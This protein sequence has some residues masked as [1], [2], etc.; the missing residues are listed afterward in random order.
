MALKNTAQIQKA[1]EGKK[2]ILITFKKHVDGD[3]MAS[4]IALKLFLEHMD[5]KADIVCDDF[6]LS[7]QYAFLK[8][9][10]KIKSKIGDL[11]QFI[12]TLDT[13]D[14]GLSELSYDMKENKLRIFITPKNG[15]ITKEQIKTSQTEFKYDLI[16]VLDTP[17][18]NALGNVYI[19]HEDFFFSTP[20][21]NIDHKSSN[22][23]FGAINIIDL[24]ASTTAEIIYTILLSLQ[25]NLINRHIA[26]AL[27]TGI[28]SGTNS[29]KKNKVRP[30]TLTIASKLVDLGADRSFIIKNLYQTKS[31]ATFKLWGSAL[32]NLQ[33]DEKYG[34]VWTILTRDDFI[35][36]GAKREDLNSIVDEL[37]TTSPDAKFILL[38]NEH[39]N[40]K[41]V[42]HIEGTLHILPSHHATDI[43]K[44]YNAEGDENHA[45][46]TI[47][48]KSITEVEQEIVE[49]IK[50][51]LTT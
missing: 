23:H 24:P 9:S 47:T 20:I 8:R 25:E 6:V 19:N 32:T 34:L 3:A 7:P 40:P 44:K 39:L 38:L 4:A 49:H 28:I 21:I 45:T 43:M 16:I 35:R 36:A 37:I 17:D 30:Q 29:F 51:H 42:H 15:Y 50:N 27:L 1:L 18:L 26:N 41:N 31:I 12:I 5:K 48:G 11:H 14:N 46:F 33:Y 10:K 22:E 13:K 2:N